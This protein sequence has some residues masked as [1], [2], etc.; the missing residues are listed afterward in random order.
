MYRTRRNANKRN[1]RNNRRLK[2]R[3]MI[4]MLDQ[5]ANPQA[6]TVLLIRKATLSLANPKLFW[7]SPSQPISL[8]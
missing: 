2:S 3:K 4:V 1:A 7:T 5:I 6:A 8:K